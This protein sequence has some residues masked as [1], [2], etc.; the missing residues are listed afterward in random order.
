MP[1]E[2]EKMLARERSRRWRTKHPERVKH[3]WRK[4]EQKH[5]QRAKVMRKKINRKWHLKLK[6]GL[7]LEQYEQLSDE[8][9]GRCGVCGTKAKLVVDHD[10]TTGK[11]R[12]LLCGPCNQGLGQFRDNCDLLRRAASYLEAHE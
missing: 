7:T 1:T 8:Q 3:T 10:H 6:Y 4:W 12:A 11:V 9:R 5:P 2:R